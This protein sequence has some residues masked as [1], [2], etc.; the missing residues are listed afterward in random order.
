MLRYKRFDA[1][2]HHK[3]SYRQR[4]RSRVPGS[5][6]KRRV[7]PLRVWNSAKQRSLA[8]R[9]HTRRSEDVRH[10]AASRDLVRRRDWDEG[11]QH[12]PK[13][14]SG[15]NRSTHRR[16]SPTPYVKRFKS[17]RYQ[18]IIYNEYVIVQS[19]K[20]TKKN[21]FFIIYSKLISYDNLKSNNFC[22]TRA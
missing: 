12:C 19:V 21:I 20:A 16:R 8:E 9:Q 6:S 5:T 14:R 2:A 7:S 18:N 3:R 15:H 17:R 1:H 10:T 22:L 13:R 11:S 4:S